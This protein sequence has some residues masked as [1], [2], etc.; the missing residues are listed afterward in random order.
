VWPSKQKHGVK[1]LQVP[2]KSSHLLLVADTLPVP[3]CVRLDGDYI[4][5]HLS[6]LLAPE[7]WCRKTAIGES[8]THTTYLTKKKIQ[9]HYKLCEWIYCGPSESRCLC[10]PCCLRLI[11]CLEYLYVRIH[12][13]FFFCFVHVAMFHNYSTPHLR[14]AFV[15]LPLYFSTP[16]P[17]KHLASSITRRTL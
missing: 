3:T 1:T 2:T 15:K 12:H 16:T 14:A 4:T 17:T 5:S 11:M 8:Q 6:Y 10:C 7:H 13:L 9:L